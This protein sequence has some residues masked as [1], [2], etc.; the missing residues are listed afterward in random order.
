MQILVLVCDE[1]EELAQIAL[2][3]NHPASSTIRSITAR[4]VTMGSFVE[5]D[6][7]GVFGWIFQGVKHYPLFVV[8][9]YSLSEM[10]PQVVRKTTRVQKRNHTKPILE[11]HAENHELWSIIVRMQHLR[12]GAKR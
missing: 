2:I 10:L 4:T 3:E 7:Y 11:I 12:Q 6:N 9:N 5:G 8:G 1:S